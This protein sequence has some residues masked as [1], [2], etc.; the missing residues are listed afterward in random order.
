MT[1]TVS[2][3][4][5][6]TYD[7]DDEVDTHEQ[8]QKQKHRIRLGAASVNGLILDNGVA[9]VVSRIV[10]TE[11]REVE[12]EEGEEEENIGCK[13]LIGMYNYMLQKRDYSS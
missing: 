9:G 7:Y 6:A 11:G 8:E 10:K 12:V 2:V 5:I 1:A 3:S 4:L 13:A